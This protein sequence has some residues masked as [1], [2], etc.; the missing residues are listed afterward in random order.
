MAEARTKTPPLIAR[1][2][3]RL[4]QINSCRPCFSGLPNII[5]SAVTNPLFKYFILI[6][7]DWVAVGGIGLSK[8]PSSGR[9]AAPEPKTPP[10][11]VVPRVRRVRG[12]SPFG[13]NVS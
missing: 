5:S 11:A 1:P 13:T 8:R 9:C 6:L 7:F 2:K 3:V 4:S 10:P 12:G